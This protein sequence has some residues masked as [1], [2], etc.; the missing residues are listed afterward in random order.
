LKLNPSSRAWRICIESEQPGADA[1]SLRF[2]EENIVFSKARWRHPTENVRRL[3]LG[4][5]MFAATASIARE[6]RPRD[7]QGDANSRPK[8]DFGDRT[9]CLDSKQ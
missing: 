8:S 7:L 1:E 4:E 3:R 2:T 5:L 6:D 9:S